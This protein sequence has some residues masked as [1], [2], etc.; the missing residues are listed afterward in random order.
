MVRPQISQVAIYK[1]ICL[2]HLPAARNVILMI[3]GQQ[4]SL[5]CFQKKKHG[6]LFSHI[7]VIVSIISGHDQQ[8]RIQIEKS[9]SIREG[10]YE[11]VRWIYCE[12]SSMVC[13]IVD[14]KDSSFYCQCKEHLISDR[15]FQHHMTFMA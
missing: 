1:M 7:L 15:S 9:V 8:C 13:C 11:K 10:S 5:G 14:R 3:L 2:Y 4:H 12:Q 6:L